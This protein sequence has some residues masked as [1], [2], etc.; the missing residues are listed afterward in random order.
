MGNKETK[1]KKV[2]K[3]DK[4]EKKKKAL[5]LDKNGKEKKTPTWRKVLITVLVIIITVLL[6]G[7]FYLYGKVGKINKIETKQERPEALSDSFKDEDVRN[8][9]LI[10]QD[11]RPGEDRSRS[12]SM[13]ICSINKKTDKIT[14]VSV[15][16]D[17]YVSI[18]DHG[19]EKINAAYVYG[20]MPLLDRTIE[21]NF[22]IHIDGN[23]EVDF[24]GF[25]KAMAEVGD[26][27]I[28]LNQEEA[29]YLNSGTGW[30]LHAGMNTLNPEQLLSYS[31][32]RYVGNS[33][34]E[35]TERQRRVIMT[36]FNK[37]KGSGLSSLLDLYE[38]VCPYLTTDLTNNEMISYIY[39]MS[40]HKMT[41]NDRAQIPVEG[42]YSEQVIDGADVLVPNLEENRAY[43]EKTL[44]GE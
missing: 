18:P 32:I 23:V 31:R 34:W 11:R 12:D 39:T 30:G 8:I 20:G 44:Y 1:R 43:L 7:Y 5:K 41:M 19:K 9:L 36:A 3:N 4:P 16:R 40:S 29:D 17:T 26:L 2:S 25:V 35:R 10:G 38:H 24:N 22:G 6:A 33:D 37:V 21:E 15:M 42:S 13:I 27:D 14:L 28:E